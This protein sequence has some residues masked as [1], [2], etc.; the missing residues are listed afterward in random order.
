MPVFRSSFR[1]VASRTSTS[2]LDQ[3]K[4]FSS[5]GRVKAA[6][7][8]PLRPAR[9]FS[10]IHMP[11]SALAVIPKCSNQDSIE[12]VMTLRREFTGDLTELFILLILRPSVHWDLVVNNVNIHKARISK[13]LLVVERRV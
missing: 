11:S 13:L 1:T 3:P 9:E 7:L 10:Y 4:P 6:R 5:F 2:S 8:S 12:R